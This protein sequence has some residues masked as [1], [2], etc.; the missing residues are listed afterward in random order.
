MRAGGPRSRGGQSMIDYAISNLA[1]GSGTPWL[2]TLSFDGVATKHVGKAKKRK[3]GLPI[4]DGGRRRGGGWIGLERRRAEDMKKCLGIEVG[5]KH[6][7]A[8]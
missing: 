4:G 3:K 1:K 5:R 2:A 7:L 8:P 6:P